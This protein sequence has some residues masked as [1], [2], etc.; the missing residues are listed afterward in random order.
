MQCPQTRSFIMNKFPVVLWEFHSKI[1]RRF[2]KTFVSF[3]IE[4]ENLQNIYHSRNILT[5]RLFNGNEVMT[6]HIFAFKFHYR[7]PNR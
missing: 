6:T 7:N 5:L 2:V 4:E 3:Q 1:E